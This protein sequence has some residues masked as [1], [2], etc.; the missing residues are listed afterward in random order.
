MQ[1]SGGYAMNTN[2]DL[3]Y[4][5]F[6]QKETGFTRTTF[7]DEIGRYHDVIEGNVNALKEGFKRPRE[8]F[9]EGKGQLSDDPLRNVMYH[10]VVGVAVVT[11]MCVDAGMD[12]N[13][14]YTL[15]D[16]YIKRGDVCRT[17][18]EVL[19]TMEQFQ[20]DM[21]QRMRDIR[22]GS[23]ISLHVKRCSDYIYEHLHENITLS[24]LAR[25]EKLNPSYLSKLFSKELGMGIKDYIIKAKIETAKN[26]LRYSDFSILDI[27]ISLGYSSQS[28]FTAAFRM[29]TGMTPKKYR[30]VYF[31]REEFIGGDANG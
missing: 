10:L 27:S 15:S 5:L 20:L 19:D 12:H 13:V 16:I 31:T 7:H 25:R 6:V 28:A 22:K 11:R 29:H 18:D 23:A 3:N 14:A 26:I 8:S 30:D 17:V 21:A 24:M 9:Y 2:R 4:R 1:K